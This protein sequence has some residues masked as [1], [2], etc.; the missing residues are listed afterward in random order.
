MT[1]SNII[2]FHYFGQILKEAEQRDIDIIPLKGAH[3]LTTVYQNEQRGPMADVDFLVKQQDW[4]RTIQMLEELNFER[5]QLPYDEIDTQ[6][7]GFHMN[8]GSNK[9]MLFEVHQF[10]FDPSRFF[11]D[12]KKLWERAQKSEFDNIPCYRMANEDIFCHIAFHASIH[13][14]M[15]LKR[16][17]RDLEL[18]LLNSD[19]ALDKVVERAKEWHCTRAVWLFLDILA[20][21]ISGNNSI[22]TKIEQAMSQLKPPLHIREALRF[23]VSPK[24]Q[25]KII[26]L[27][28]RVQASIVWPLIFDSKQLLAKMLLHHPLSPL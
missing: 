26:S 10:L 5:R 20:G 1:P 6:E 27:N 3:L 23:I 22:N 15:I 18:L 14:L 11:I 24:E 19:L 12:H 16:T 17:T 7:M 4:L 2:L 8:I 21:K 28:H 25:T 13:R 9:K